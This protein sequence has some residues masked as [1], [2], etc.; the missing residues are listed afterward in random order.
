MENMGK[1]RR[2]THVKKESEDGGEQK[3]EDIALNFKTKKTLLR[4]V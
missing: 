2:R 3:K 4:P 1:K